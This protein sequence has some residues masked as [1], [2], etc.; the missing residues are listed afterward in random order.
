MHH[1]YLTPDYMGATG[2]E[3]TTDE[4]EAF[5]AMLLFLHRV[6]AMAQL[7]A[8]LGQENWQDCLVDLEATI[9]QAQASQ[10]VAY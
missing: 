6:K 8:A 5:D 2:W 9:S 3:M 1:D 10:T 4:R 7:E